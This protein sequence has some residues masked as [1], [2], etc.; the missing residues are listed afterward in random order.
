M[1]ASIV[2][3]YGTETLGDRAILDGIICILS[4]I[5]SKNEIRIGSLF[6]FYTERTMHEDISIYQQYADE[7]E[8]SIFDSKNTK[9]MKENITSSDILIVGGGPLMDLEELY[10]LRKSFIIAKKHHIPII[11]LGC[12]I[13]PLNKNNYI[14][15]VKE[16]LIMADE[17]LLRDAFSL[18]VAQALIGNTDKIKVLG[19]P[20]VISIE[21]YKDRT[22]INRSNYVAINFRE[23]TPQEYGNECYYS[24]AFAREIIRYVQSHYEK[25]LLVPMHNFS[26]G[27][28]DRKFLSQAVL[29]QEYD[30]VHVMH[31]T[32]NLYELYNV[33]ANAEAC[34]GMRYHSIVMQTILNGNNFIM[35]YTNP[36]TGKISGFI[37]SLENK[38][39]Y[40]N[41]IIKLQK[42]IT[43]DK[44]DLLNVILAGGRY[45]YINS[46][47]ESK[48]TDILKSYVG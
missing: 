23:Y 32:M 25:V 38:E 17:V 9:R 16:L 6:D 39:F 35:D 37:S 18:Q 34:I 48:Y 33:Y 2:G 29:N 22:K 44:Y 5:H 40:D 14:N 43:K 11:I 47:M 45:T 41:R 46:E 4:K 26:I 20:A 13:G 42:P 7:T 36:S 19:D 30:N 8:I 10:I 21:N 27:G 1:I 15:V 28:D 31:E 24:I 12:G 3:W